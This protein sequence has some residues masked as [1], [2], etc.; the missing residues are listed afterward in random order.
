MIPTFRCFTKID[1][2]FIRY[3]LIFFLTLCVAIGTTLILFEL[4][5]NAYEAFNLFDNSEKNTLLILCSFYLFR[6]LS[7]L[8]SWGGVVILTAGMITILYLQGVKT[9]QGSQ[10]M[11][12]MT[13][14]FSRGRISVPFIIFG[15]FMILCITF[16]REIV[17]PL[18]RDCPG[19]QNDSFMKSSSSLTSS[20]R[21]YETHIILSASSVDRSSR[22]IDNPKFILP[23]TLE[24]LG[25]IVLNADTANWRDSTEDTPGGYLLNNVIGYEKIH[26]ELKFIRS[27]K[28]TDK[29]LPRY[30]LIHEDHPW[31]QE[32]QLF[33]QFKSPPEMLMTSSSSFFMPPLNELFASLDEPGEYFQCQKRIQIHS[34]LIQPLA[35]SILLVLG[36]AIL[37]SGTS[38]SMKRIPWMIGMVILFMITLFTAQSAGCAGYIPLSVAAWFPILLFTP[39]M[40]WFCCA[41]NE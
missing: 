20:K 38:V 28:N 7:L 22:T 14:G 18:C 19:V 29:T 12:V 30:I 23:N 26:E 4:L 37:L 40:V 25:G 31:I 17:F 41:M 39:I 11:P 24:S 13:S 21:D 27:E 10:L 36:I 33:V 5:P 6:T 9:K 34:R 2:Y 3:N 1:R 16:I 15:L 35:D 8:N 32:K